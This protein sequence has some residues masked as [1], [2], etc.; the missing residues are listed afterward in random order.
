MG[1]VWIVLSTVELSRVD[2]AEN[3]GSLRG[4][5]PRGFASSPYPCQCRLAQGP[6]LSFRHDQGSLGDSR[7][8]SMPYFFGRGLWEEDIGYNM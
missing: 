8:R 7:G 2:W 5:C 1:H 6:G 4:S 3:L